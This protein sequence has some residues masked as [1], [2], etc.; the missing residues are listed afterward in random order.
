[1]TRWQRLAWRLLALLGVAAL[2]KFAVMWFAPTVVPNNF[3]GPEHAVDVLVYA[4]LTFVVW[5]RILMDLLLWTIS[6]RIRQT[7]SVPPPQEGLRVAFIT[8]FVPGCEPLEMLERTLTSLRDAD[9]PHDTWV[10]D[11]GNGRDVQQLCARLGV[12]HFSR[13]G[14]AQWNTPDGRFAAKTKGGNHNAWYD[15]NAD[16]Y[17]VVAQIDT[18][19]IADRNFLTATLGH[20]NDPAVAWV[21]TPQIYGNIG[22]SVVARG[23]AQQN[24]SFY[25]PLLRGLSDRDMCLMIGANHIV[26]VAALRSVG[27][28]EGHLTEDLATGMKMHSQGWKSRYVPLALAV[29]E[30]P[31][32]WT[33]YFNQQMRW[34]FGST[35]ILRH[36][37]FRAVRTMNL[38]QG[39]YYLWLQLNYFSGLTL[40]V[41][42]GLL[43][44]YFLG[45]VSAA[46]LPLKPLA[47]A[48]GP[49]LV[50][51]FASTLW[52]QRLNVQ[53]G[54]E[55]G[56]LLAGRLVQV[57]ASP[58]Y[59]LAI[60][61]VALG[62]RIRFMVTP[63]GL[64]SVGRTPLSAFQLHTAL[65]L[66]LGATFAA[67]EVLHR[68]A[69]APIAWVT[70]TTVIMVSF[71]LGEMSR[72]ASLAVA[73]ASRS[74]AAGAAI[75][76]AVTRPRARK[77]LRLTLPQQR[78]G[79]PEVIDLTDEALARRRAM[80][81]YVVQLST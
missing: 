78:V 1:M 5:Q 6:R 66:V 31:S 63:K 62:R 15:A 36:Q 49:F 2:A 57:A 76:V 42:A 37:T 34:A 48:Y 27:F 38:R 41:S 12:K 21:G 8:T 13:H 53:P 44:A 47:L 43:M 75:Q 4:A 50:W 67:G 17:D 51:R 14:V 73:T 7:E 60:V 20:F 65:A 68:T 30:G 56:L 22:E 35:H 55:R 81:A 26:R 29:G 64:G 61:Q 25:G 24:W 54:Q 11:E 71:L 69:W 18:D 9:Y 40:L 32:T 72:R 16:A 46:D 59:A 79:E 19:F 45:G 39:L 33:A 77:T 3:S 74:L 28:Y 23:A 52:M 10:L 80:S 70:V 58:I